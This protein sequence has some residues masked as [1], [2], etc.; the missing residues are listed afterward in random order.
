MTAPMYL[1]AFSVKQKLT[2]MVNRYEINETNPD[3]SVGR[4]MAVAQQ[5][6]M[7]LKEQVTFFADEGRSQP[8]F[9][10]AAR[11]VMDLGAGYDVRD[12]A[13][14]PLGMFRKDFGQSLLRSTF[15]LS[16]PDLEAT[17]RER[18]QVIAIVRRFVDFPLP[19]HFDFHDQATGQVVMTSDRQMSLRDR[20]QIRVPDP[21]LDF[22]VAAAMAVGLDALLAR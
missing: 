5:K 6:R 12:A 8:V 22:R 19:F 9:S 16:A 15:H 1:P 11:Q 2:M 7:A 18:N 13:G 21:R 14:T 4:L 3:G 20:Y 17:G 10:F